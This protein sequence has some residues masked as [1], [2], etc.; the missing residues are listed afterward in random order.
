MGAGGF[1]E[2]WLN[3]GSGNFVDSGQRLLDE[4]WSVAIGD[5][6]GDRDLDIVTGSA[7][8]TTRPRHSNIWLNDGTGRFADSGQAPAPSCWA[9]AVALGDVDG[10]EDLDV[11]Y[12]CGSSGGTSGGTLFD[13]LYLNDGSGNFTKSPQGL[14]GSSTFGLQFGDLDLDG[15]LDVF[16]V[17]GDQRGG[18]FADEIWTN[19]GTGMFSK[20]SQRLGRSNGRAVRLGDLDDDGDLDAVVGNGTTLENIGNVKGQPNVIWLNDGK[21]NFSEWQEMGNAA[22]SAAALGDLDND[23][24]LDAVFGNIDQHNDVWFNTPQIAGDA[25]HDG[26]FNTADIIQV[27]QAGEYMDGVEDNSIW[28]EGDW[29]GDGD[30]DNLDL[31]TALQEGL[32][33][34]QSL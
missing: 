23:G 20:T 14:S 8:L 16:V 6:D 12:G 9:T 17:H 7:V 19:D 24:D 1:S 13:M 21:G 2:I 31:V 26:R 4:A 15:D 5:V 3:D 18:N 29:N 22:T 28:E 33:Q 34:R 27:L 25:N 30:F 32:Y 10:D 11:M